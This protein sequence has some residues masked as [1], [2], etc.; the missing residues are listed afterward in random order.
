VV[1]IGEI[2]LDTKVESPDLETQ[3][4]VLKVQLALAADLDLPV[5][6]HCRGA[7]HEM[8]AAVKEHGGNLRGIIHAWTR[9]PELVKAFYPTGLFFGL[10]GAVTRP[11]AK[12]ARRSAKVLPLQRIVLE[13]DAPSIGLDGVRPEETEPQHVADVAA[14]LAEIKGEDPATVAGETTRNAESLF[15]FVDS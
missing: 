7:F 15:G 12:Q 4:A 14:A 6:L 13:T 5:I 3:L 9:G 2:G 10:G 1:A 8:V 11:N